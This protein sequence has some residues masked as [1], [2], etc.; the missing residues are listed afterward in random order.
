[1]D[2]QTDADHS[3]SADGPSGVYETEHGQLVIYEESQPDAYVRSD[4]FVDIER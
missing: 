3:G 2:E 4:L 1:M